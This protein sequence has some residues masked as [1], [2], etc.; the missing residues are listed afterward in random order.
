VAI[1]Q[2]KGLT[3]SFGG[4]QAVADIDFTLDEQ[5]ILGIIGPNGAGKTTLLNLVTGFLKPDCGS[6]TFEGKDIT[7]AESDE[8]ARRG[9]ARTFQLVKPFANLTALDNAAIGRLHGAGPAKNVKQAREEAGELLHFVGLGEKKSVMAGNLTFAERRKLELA[10]ALGAKP[11]LLLLDEVI[12]G[13]NTVE[14]EAAMETIKEIHGLRIAIVFVE[15]VMKAVMELSTRVVVL[16][17]GRK[18]AEGAPADVIADP[19]VVES[20]LGG[21]F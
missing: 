6:I 10:R 3:K 2:I 7:S 4:L 18:I 5:E 14:T 13:L 21:E 20:Y 19:V 1:L 15:H 17:A 8:V 11:R 12:A 9:I 16:D